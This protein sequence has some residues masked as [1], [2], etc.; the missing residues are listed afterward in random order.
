MHHLSDP[1]KAAALA[2]TAAVVEPGGLIVV[3]DRVSVDELLFRDWAVVWR[4]LGAGAPETY[5][6]HVEELT[7][8]GDRPARLQDQLAWM[9]AAGLHACCLHL[10]GNRAVLVARKP[11]SSS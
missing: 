4:R 1:D 7:H 11:E 8:A 10:Y 3:I 2:W 5:A 6:E 9:E